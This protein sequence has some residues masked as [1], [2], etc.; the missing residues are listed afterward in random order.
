MQRITSRHNAI[1]AAYRAAARGGTEGLLL[2]GSHLVGEALSAGI[3]LRHVMV[4]LDAIDSPELTPLLDQLSDD[5]DVAAASSAVM[6]AVS[7]VRSSSR[8]VALGDRPAP[9][10]APFDDPAHLVVVACDVQDPGNVGAI[11]RVAEGA[12]A[13]GVVVAGQSADPFAWKALRGSMGSALRLPIVAVPTI[14]AA[15]AE[16]RRHGSAVVA[17]VPR[18]GVPLF[19]SR[20][21]GATTL[22]VGGEG[23]GLPAPVVAGAD[24]RLTI[25]ME[26]PVES[27][28]AAVATAVLL[29][30][31]RRQRARRRSP[32][33]RAAAATRSLYA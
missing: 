32:G 6:A 10:R 9:V 25:P 2:D 26:A 21:D 28:N 31:A 20:L 4:A 29:Y 13:S 5:V 18:D 17:T 15:V 3:R 12:G 33:G 30:E 11:V 8:I 1:V 16:A 19:D 27:L 24:F 23:S 7:P 22:L 14:E